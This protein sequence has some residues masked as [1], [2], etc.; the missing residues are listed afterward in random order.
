MRLPISGKSF[1]N[2]SAV[3]IQHDGSVGIPALQRRGA[4]V[5]RC[6]PVEGG[7]ANRAGTCMPNIESYTGSERGAL[8]VPGNSPFQR[9]NDLIDGTDYLDGAILIW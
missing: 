4:Q 1:Q 2:T 3:E 6:Q 7:I 9:R 8:T 5:K